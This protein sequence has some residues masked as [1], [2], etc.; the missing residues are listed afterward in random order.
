VRRAWWLRSWNAY[1]GIGFD[2]RVRRAGG[3]ITS[4]EE[5]SRSTVQATGV[6]KSGLP[7]APERFAAGEQEAALRVDDGRPDW[8]GEPIPLSPPRPQLASFLFETG[9]SHCMRRPRQSV[10]GALCYERQIVSPRRTVFCLPTSTGQ[11]R[12]SWTHGTLLKRAARASPCFT[13]GHQVHLYE[14]NTSP[15]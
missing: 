14:C 5:M 3:G 7:N 9:A 13:N 1:V 4:K 12:R 6:T 10:H 8:P 11:A 15:S 2:G